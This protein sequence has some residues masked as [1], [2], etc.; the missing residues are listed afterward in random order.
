M[1]RFGLL[2]TL[3]AALLLACAG[4]VLAQQSAGEEEFIASTSSLDAGDPIPGRYIVVLKDEADQQGARGT[5]QARV[6]AAQVA[7]ELAQ[8]TSVEEVTHVYRNALNGFAARIPARRLDDVRSDPRVDFVAQDLVVKASAQALPTGVNRVEADESST[9]ADNGSGAVNANIAILDTGIYKHRDLSVAGGYN[10]TSNKRRAWGDGNGHG[11]HVAGTAAARDNGRGV[12]GVAPGARL[13]AVK[14]LNNNGSGSFSSVICGV[15][16]VTANAAAKGIKVANMSLGATVLGTDDD[17]CGWNGSNAAAALH[18]AICNSVAAGVFYAVAAGNENKDFAQLGLSDAP[19][20]FNQ[21]LTV[22]AM[23]DHDGEPG[24]QGISTCHGNIDD[25]AANFSNWTSE[26]NT[27]DQNHTIAA[28]GV[29]IRSTWKNG[30]YRTVSGTS[31]ASPHVAGTAAL[32]IAAPLT[33]PNGTCA[34]MTPIQIIDKLR[35][36]AETRSGSDPTVDDYYG[37][38]GDPNT[39]AGVYYGFLVYAG[40]Y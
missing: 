24:S 27:T 15:N 6:D 2:I 31:M 14:V 4:V 21:V 11:T 28:P 25:T 38:A 36:D 34:G 30:R 39:S 23:A 33:A 3:A 10:C 35:S 13:W 17:N 37:F 5:E 16:W 18:Q 7:D 1:G 12:V 26:V 19:A 40:G 29:C 22:T 32:C 20:A 9:D 8:E